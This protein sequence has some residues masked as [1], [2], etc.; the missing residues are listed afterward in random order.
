M[1]KS[2][3]LAFFLAV[4]CAICGV[5]L[6]GVNAITKPVI[7]AANSVSYVDGTYSGTAS[8]FG[9]DINVTVTISGGVITDLTYTAD[10]ETPSVGGVAL[11]QLSSDILEAGSIDVDTIGGATFSSNGM[12]DAIRNALNSASGSASFEDGTYS[13]SAKGFGGEINVEFTVSGGSVTDISI[14]GDAETAS[15]G[16]VAIEDITAQILETGSLEFD[17]VSGATYTSN[18]ISDAIANAGGQQ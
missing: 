9:G 16:G 13:G 5:A 14:V 6:A 12:F 10:S 7:E 18:G 2:A 11:E 8:G 1:K 15:V 17:A 3:Y 4:V